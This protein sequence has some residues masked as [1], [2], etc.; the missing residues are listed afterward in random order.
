[1]FFV[2][3]LVSISIADRAEW[4]YPGLNVIDD[5]KDVE[6]Y[7]PSDNNFIS[8]NDSLQMWTLDSLNSSTGKVINVDTVIFISPSEVDTTIMFMSND[9]FHITT[10]DSTIIMK[11]GS[12]SLYTSD[13]AIWFGNSYINPFVYGF[14]LG[15]W[16]TV[17]GNY[18]VSWGFNNNSIADYTTSWGNNCSSEGENSTSWGENTSA[19]GVK[20]TVWGD[21]N[22][23][24]GIN[25]TVFGLLNTGTKQ[26]SATWGVTSNNFGLSTT[27]AGT[28]HC[29]A[30]STANYSFLIGLN[31]TLTADSTFRSAYPYNEFK[32]SVRVGDG[33]NRI[34]S[35]EMIG[36]FVAIITESDTFYC[37]T[38]TTSF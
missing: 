9:T 13:K 31:D 32:G 28:Y 24:I 36:S 20:S 11:L 2:F 34:I 38:D 1:M 10:D 3:N 12:G 27:L 30:D 18:S 37:A 4:L 7:N 26:N 15:L 14:S 35:I 33:G 16:D 8:W 29:Q 17:T 19:I 23:S 6:A 5:L 21:F 22:S 25:S